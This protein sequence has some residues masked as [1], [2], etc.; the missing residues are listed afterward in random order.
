MPANS[1]RIP[2]DRTA[3]ATLTGHVAS[4]EDPRAE[5]WDVAPME[6]VT[7]PVCLAG[8]QLGEAR[9]VC[10]F[11]N[12]REDEYRVTLP[13]ILD[14]LDSGDK[15]IHIVDPARRSDHL[16]RLIATG[17]DVASKQ[18]SGQLAL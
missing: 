3:C 18:E 9:H 7:A 14:G 12:S 17:I 13:F 6:R 2:V 10:A 1:G 16:Q 15:M 5:R 4:A 11:F 8:S